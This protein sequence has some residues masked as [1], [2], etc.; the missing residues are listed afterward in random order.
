MSSDKDIVDSKNLSSSEIIDEGVFTLYSKPKLITT[1][2]HSGVSN[3]G[4]LYDIPED[5]FQGTF[6]IDVGLLEDYRHPSYLT[7][8]GK[9]E[10]YPSNL[11]YKLK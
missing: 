8:G 3:L 7:V 11:E 6:Y 10:L 9:K 2:F 1:E 5:E 4:N